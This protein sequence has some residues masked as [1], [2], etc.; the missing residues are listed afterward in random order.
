MKKV[1]RYSTPILALTLGL[2]ACAVIAKWRATVELR[3]ANFNQ[4]LVDGS[5]NVAHV[6]MDNNALH[7]STYDNKGALIATVDDTHSVNHAS[8]TQELD[9]GRML[10]IGSTLNSSL[11][12]DAN[13]GSVAPI[14]SSLLPD[15]AGDWALTGV[16]SALGSQIAIYGT[17]TV[18]DIA[19]PWI[20]LW[21]LQNNTFTQTDIPSLDTIDTLFSQQ[22]VIVQGTLAGERWVITL[23]AAMNELGR[24]ALSDANENLIGDSL[25]RA[26]LFD[27]ST[28]NVDVLNFDGTTAWQYVNNEYH[29]IRGE[30]VGPD[31]SVLLWGDHANYSIL[32]FR[33]DNAHFLRLTPDGTLAYHY[34]A[35]DSDMAK[36]DYRNIRQFKDG[37]IQLSVQGL[38]GELAGLVIFDGKFGVP[39]RTTKV[40]QHDYVSP[41]GKQTRFMREPIRVEVISRT[42]PLLIEVV[43]QSGGHCNNRDVFNAGKSNLV[44]LSEL[45]GAANPSVVISYY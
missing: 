32:A 24:F 2:S 33:T 41:L 26:A 38:G 28:Q 31:G 15:G 40:I 25:G 17:R 45:C 27:S 4:V 37:S 23:D 22:A 19:Q 1:L 16:T 5:G 14:D 11:I 21:D 6:F 35:G 39:Y 13:T 20:L 30:S 7:I 43:S 42:A 9:T 29:Y 12:V 34:R 36:I 44:S 3:P 8:K 18:N 10:I